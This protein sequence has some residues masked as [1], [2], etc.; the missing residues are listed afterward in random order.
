MTSHCLL[1]RTIAREAS[2]RLAKPTNSINISTRLSLRQMST[3]VFQP[4][5]RLNETITMKVPTMGDS[6]TEGTIVE[7]SV[8]KGEAVKEGDVI[9][10]VETDKV[11]IDIKAETDGVIVE[12]FGVVDD[13]VEIGADLYQI[14]TEGVATA[15]AADTP[16]S[17][18]PGVEE[19]ETTTQ[20][21]AS[22]VAATEEG[23]TGR[24]PSIQF[25]GK[26]GWKEKLSV[27]ADSSPQNVA[28]AEPLKP[29]AS[30]ILEGGQLPPTYGRLPFSEREMEALIMGGASESP[31]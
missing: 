28:P 4:T 5:S 24:K 31:L 14:D 20:N 1:S 23:G 13:E 8:Q 12:Q 10:L 27:V 11:T 18:A 21:E 2:R 16:D 22:V 30:F 6:I 9:L 19:A 15:T 25:L 26:T 3:G 7:W 17:P 29:N